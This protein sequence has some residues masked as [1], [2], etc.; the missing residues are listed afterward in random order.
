MKNSVLLV[1][2][3]IFAVALMAQY[4]PIMTGPGTI[5]PIQGAWAQ[6]D[7]TTEDGD[8]FDVRYAIV[9]EHDCGD[10]GQ[11]VD[12]Y[13]FEYRMKDKKSGE[14]TIT[15]ILTAGDPSKQQYTMRMVTQQNDEKPM[16]LVYKFS[17]EQMEEAESTAEETE[18]DYEDYEKMDDS[19]EEL[20]TET[21]TVPAGTFKCYHMEVKGDKG[22]TEGEY[23]FSKDVAFMGIV[24]SKDIDGSEMILTAYDNSG[25][26]SEITGE[27]EVVEIPTS[28]DEYFKELG[29][30]FKEGAK[31][32]VKEGVKEGAKESAKEEAKKGVKKGIKSLIGF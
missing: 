27:P 11:K 10:E 28:A 19:I 24:K 4:P 3:T 7:M 18:Y 6:Y 12:C 9:G 14:K 30:S 8:E 26:E 15:K 21:I 23:W 17:E 20:G 25:A 2:V 32:G 5:D 22:K 31:E 13:W 1:I 29:E 16:E